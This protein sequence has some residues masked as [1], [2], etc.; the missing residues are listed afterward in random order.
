MSDT[1]QL[2][3]VLTMDASKFQGAI[4]NAI[5]SLGALGGA[6]GPAVLALGAVGLAIGAVAKTISDSV[7]S[8]T[9]LTESVHKFANM[10][11]AT[12][13]ESSRLIGAAKNLGIGADSLTR[14]FVGLERQM[15]RQPKT[16]KQLGISIEDVGKNGRTV[17]DVFKDVI[18]VAQRQASLTDRNTIAFKAFGVGAAS[19]MPFLDLTRQQLEGMEAAIK[20]VMSEEDVRKAKELEIQ[21]AQMADAWGAVG[22]AI[23]RVA[24]PAITYFGN[25]LRA[26]WMQTNDLINGDFDQFLKDGVDQLQKETEGMA[27]AIQKTKEDTDAKNALDAAYQKLE[28][29]AKNFILT[30]RESFAKQDEEVEQ[31]KKDYVRNLTD[32]RDQFTELAKKHKDSIASIQDDLK[33]LDDSYKQSNEDRLDSYKQSVADEITQHQ[34]ALAT[35][36]KELAAKMEFGQAIDEEE[37][38]NLQ[39]KIKKEEDFLAKHAKIT[40]QVQSYMGKD[41]IDKLTE[42]YNRAQMEADK[43]NEV[44]KKSLTDRLADE[45][46]SYADQNA[47]LVKNLERTE[48]DYKEHLVKISTDFE[49]Q[50]GSMIAR[51]DEPIDGLREEIKSLGGDDVLGALNN[52]SVYAEKLSRGL[53]DVSD[54]ATSARTSISGGGTSGGKVTNPSSPGYDTS[55]DEVKSAGGLGGTLATYGGLAMGALQGVGAIGKAVGD[56]ED[57]IVN[58]IIKSV[59]HYGSGGD[60]SADGLA[61]LHA[62][63]KVTPAGGGK[64]ISVNFYGDT[65]FNSQADEDRFVN[66]IRKVLMQDNDN[67]KLGVY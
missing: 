31:L 13:E 46:T 17:I 45:N 39:A 26:V 51:M 61:Y 18:S 21:T 29:D 42:Q 47:K 67:A 64:G 3:A 60:V 30:V 4:A 38:G 14:V 52:A 7:S 50:L 66:K 23:A 54:A 28:K 9:S 35:A 33:K 24:V 62:G 22:D 36:K 65:N 20:R 63:E 37:I 56:W 2:N 32:I 6:L 57:K 11:G 48:T 8:Y 19:A 59:K 15:A 43:S 12:T 1:G 44:Q 5:Q 40:S 27:A 25:A 34:E 53:N 16:F 55:N 49:K 41:T 10:T 58:G